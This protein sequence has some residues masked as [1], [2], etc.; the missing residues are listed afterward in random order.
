MGGLW[1]GEHKPVMQTFLKPFQEEL[2]GLE[3]QGTEY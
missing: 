2:S 1:F 3:I